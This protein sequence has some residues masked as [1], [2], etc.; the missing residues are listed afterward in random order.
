MKNKIY[1]SFSI[2]LLFITFFTIATGDVV[3]GVLDHT[4]SFQWIALLIFCLLLPLLNA[5]EII[6]NRDSWNVLYWIGLALNAVTIFFITRF[7]KIELFS[8]A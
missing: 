2:V 4:L 8:L 5:A 7:F 6:I 1:L 3:F